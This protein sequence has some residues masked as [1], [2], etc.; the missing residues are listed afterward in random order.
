MNKIISSIRKIPSWLVMLLIFGFLYVTGLH[1]DAIALIQRAFLKVGFMDADVPEINSINYDDVQVDEVEVAEKMQA[2]NFRMQNLS[3]ENVD[4]QKLKG[5]TIFMNLWATWCPPCRAEMP[6]IQQLYEKSASEDV[7]FVMLTLDNDMEK[8]HEF[9][10]KYDYNF[11]VYKAIS[12][13]PEAFVSNSIPT[14]FIIS[15]Y[16]D[17]VFK[18]E[19]VADYDTEEVKS[20]LKSM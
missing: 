11:P 10:E 2:L 19:G 1:T 18:K 3:G 6:G 20:F 8:V 7:V 17:I 12:N 13:L 4:F 5:K 14:T 16:G 9:M 15:P